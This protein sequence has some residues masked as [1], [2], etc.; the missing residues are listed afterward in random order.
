MYE[1]MGNLDQARAIRGIP[2]AET[3]PAGQGEA[4]LHLVTLE[5]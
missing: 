3:N 4:D 1:A 2:A 5:S